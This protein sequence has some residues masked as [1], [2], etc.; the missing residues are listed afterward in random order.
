YDK[1]TKGFQGRSYQKDVDAYLDFQERMWGPVKARKKK[2]PYRIFHEG[3]HEQRIKRVVNYSP[4]LEGTLDLKDLGVFDYY[5]KVVE[6][7]GGTPGVNVVDGVA[8]AHYFISGVSGRAISSEHSAYALLTKRFQSSTQ[9]HVHTFD[10]CV[11]TDGNGNK[12]MG[13]VAGCYQD[14]HSDWAGDINRFWFPG[15]A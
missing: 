6:Y 11:R 4:E 13:L 8:Y 14:Y 1:G 3:N 15:V 10:Y 7:D 2:L 9:G 5:D 12:M